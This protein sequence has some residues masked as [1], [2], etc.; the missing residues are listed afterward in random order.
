MTSTASPDAPA[1]VVRR[2]AHRRRCQAAWRVARENIAAAQADAR[3]AQHRRR[4]DA[5]DA[6]RQPRL[7]S[8]SADLEAAEHAR[9]A[10]ALATAAELTP[11]AD[12]AEVLDHRAEAA[13]GR[14]AAQA[15]ALEALLAAL[16]TPEP[17]AQADTPARRLVLDLSP[18][19]RL[20]R[21]SPL[22]AHAPPVGRLEAVAV[23]W[24]PGHLLTT[25]GGN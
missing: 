10:Q 19:G 13:A 17:P 12:A 24:A 8:W 9:A 20:V 7:C 4:L 6:D 23:G 2:R 22:T 14:R 15:D 11:L 5:T 1:E 18:P 25:A 3:A 16:D 21:C